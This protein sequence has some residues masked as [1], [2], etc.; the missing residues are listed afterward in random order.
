VWGEE[1]LKNSIH[2]HYLLCPE[3]KYEYFKDI[4]RNAP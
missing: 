4:L 3:G 2:R 1:A